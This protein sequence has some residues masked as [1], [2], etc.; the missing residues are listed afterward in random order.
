[1]CPVERRCRVEPDEDDPEV[2]MEEAGD[3]G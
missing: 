1:M 3:A 2:L